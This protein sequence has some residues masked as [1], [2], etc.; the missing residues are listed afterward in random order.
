V[1]RTGGGEQFAELLPAAIPASVRALGL[2]LSSALSSP[3][4]ISIMLF[5]DE[6]SSMVAFRPLPGFPQLVVNR[7]IFSNQ[8][9]AAV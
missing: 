6:L 3:P 9:Q 5:G 7:Q 2:L 4:T 8:P 1:V